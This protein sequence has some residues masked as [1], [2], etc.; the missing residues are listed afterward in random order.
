MNS[1]RAPGARIMAKAM[2]KCEI[3]F[4]NDIDILPDKSVG[5]LIVKVRAKS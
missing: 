1:P 4:V 3:F 5:L 2:A